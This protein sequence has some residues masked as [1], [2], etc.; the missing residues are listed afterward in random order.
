MISYMGVGEHFFHDKVVVHLLCQFPPLLQALGLLVVFN[1]Q[2][3]RY[4]HTGSGQSVSCWFSTYTLHPV[5]TGKGVK[6][7]RIRVRW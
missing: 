5:V 7:R 1:L 2:F 6:W 4:T 3:K